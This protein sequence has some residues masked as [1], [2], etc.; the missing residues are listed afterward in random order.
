MLPNDLDLVLTTGANPN[1]TPTRPS[2]QGFCV[3]ATSQ[4]IGARCLRVTRQKKI[5][6]LEEWRKKK[7]KVSGRSTFPTLRGRPRDKGR[8]HGGQY[9][10]LEVDL[11]RSLKGGRQRSTSGG[12]PLVLSNPAVAAAQKLLGA[13]GLD[14]P[15]R[16]IRERILVCIG[17]PTWCGG[18][19]RKGHRA[20][21]AKELA[22]QIARRNKTLVLDEYLTSQLCP[23]CGA[24]LER[25]RAKHVRFWRCPTCDDADTEHNKD[26]LAALSL[27]Q[28]GL[29]LLLTGR[30]PTAWQRP[31]K[32]VVT[33]TSATTDKKR[34]APAA[35][36]KAKATNAR[37]QGATPTTGAA[38]TK[39]A[40]KQQQQEARVDEA[41][42]GQVD[43]AS[44]PRRQRRVRQQDRAP[45]R[46]RC[47]EA[48]GGPA[49]LRGEEGTP[50][51]CRARPGELAQR[52]T[53][54]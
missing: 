6:L 33:S 18:H 24:Q 53:Q 1:P 21:P 34:K 16:Q 32:K 2:A 22:K 23:H 46:Q 20:A 50:A 13:L 52:R 36:K 40:R 8:Y 9:H 7:K 39:R 4:V 5:K 15:P 27:I 31:E 42:E 12:R 11:W 10:G 51:G 14:W 17:N 19:H 47:A 26:F 45:A 54:Q 44:R 30:R 35:K 29:S 25:T 49:Q 48:R 28:I 43:L 38:V 37:K 41:E 3:Q